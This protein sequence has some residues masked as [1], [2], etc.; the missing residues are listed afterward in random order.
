MPQ[1]HESARISMEGGLKTPR[2][3]NGWSSNMGYIY[4]LIQAIVEKVLNCFLTQKHCSIR[5]FNNRSFISSPEP[6]G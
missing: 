3:A 2:Q 4:L 6:L 1:S 5:E